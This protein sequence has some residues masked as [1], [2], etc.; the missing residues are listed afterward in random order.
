M[1][2]ESRLSQLIF[3]LQCQSPGT[4]DARGGADWVIQQKACLVCRSNATAPE[5]TMIP[6]AGRVEAKRE[7]NLAAPPLFGMLGAK[8]TANGTMAHQPKDATQDLRSTTTSSIII[9]FSPSPGRKISTRSVII[10]SR[11]NRQLYCTHDKVISDNHTNNV[12]LRKL[13]G[14]AP[15]TYTCTCSGLAPADFPESQGN[16][17]LADM[18]R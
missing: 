11:V 4:Q 7:G 9:T 16:H 15:L 3:T 17:Q 8:G 13:A 2:F 5:S 1:Y 6:A 18:L 14:W 10:R 12:R